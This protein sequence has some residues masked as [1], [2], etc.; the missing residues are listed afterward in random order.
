M[1]T[2][3]KSLAMVLALSMVGAAA[4]NAEACGGNKSGGRSGGYG[5]G[6]IRVGGGY[7]GGYGNVPS[8]GHCSSNGGYPS[9]SYPKGGYPGNGYPGGG[10]PIDQNYGQAYEPYHSMYVCQPGDSFYTVSLKEYGTSAVANHI[11]QFNRLQPSAALV[12]GQR[13]MLP[14]VSAAGKLTQSQAPAPFVDGG[15]PVAATRPTPQLTQATETTKA[16]LAARSMA[17]E[18][19]PELPKVPVGSTLQLDGTGFGNEQGVARLRVSGLSLPVTVLEWSNTSA[20]VRLPEVEVT[21]AVKAEV[22]VLRADG[23][24]ASSTSM[25]LIATASRLAQ[26]N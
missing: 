8:S 18:S 14:S 5:G 15:A 7:G 9:D 20:K 13:L 12:P 25:E 26:A 22:E 19:E 10:Y 16:I 24:L 23:S 17:V 3:I 21:G 1:T 2:T 4:T 11:A 6:I